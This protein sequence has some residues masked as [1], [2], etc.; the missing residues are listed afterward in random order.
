LH[1]HSATDAY[2]TVTPTGFSA[3]F[4]I[5]ALL[6]MLTLRAGRLPARRA[7][8]QV[9]HGTVGSGIFKASWENKCHVR[10]RRSWKN[11]M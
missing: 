9:R 7:L 2:L 4:L 5:A 10:N 1:A 8:T 11:A 6:L 3:G